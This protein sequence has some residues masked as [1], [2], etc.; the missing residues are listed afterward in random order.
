ML[1]IVVVE[2]CYLSGGILF[3]LACLDV[4]FV[5]ESRKANYSI[6]R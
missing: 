6:Y 3:H 1:S 5:K 4:V 2:R